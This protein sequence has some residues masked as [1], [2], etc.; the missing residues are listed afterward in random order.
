M[1]S[2]T[3]V[4]TDAPRPEDVDRAYCVEGAPGVDGRWHDCD[5]PP[6]HAGDHWDEARQTSWRIEEDPTDA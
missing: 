3:A 1:P 2:L 6:D 4:L 5:R